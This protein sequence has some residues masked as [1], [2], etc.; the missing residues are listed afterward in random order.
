MNVSPNNDLLD[1][2]K[3]S[4]DDHLDILKQVF[5]QL[6]KARLKINAAKLFFCTQ[7]TEYLEYILSRGENKLQPK[8]CRQSL[9]L[10]CAIM[11]KNFDDSLVWSN[12]IGI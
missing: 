8:R 11:T 10:I 12:T 2:T 3:H 1:V 5:I 9:R 7:E 6:C 4:L